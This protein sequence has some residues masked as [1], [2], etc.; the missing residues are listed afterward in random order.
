MTVASLAPVAGVLEHVQAT[1]R[2]APLNPQA[3]AVD[4]D[5]GSG[6]RKW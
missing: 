3:A 2:H 1:T 6:W 4:E 5:N